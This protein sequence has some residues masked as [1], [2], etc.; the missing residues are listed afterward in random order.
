MVDVLG[1]QHA[2]YHELV[3]GPEVEAEDGRAEEEPRPGHEAVPVR[4]QEEI[5]P[6]APR[7]PDEREHLIGRLRLV[8]RPVIRQYAERSHIVQPIDHRAPAPDLIESEIRNQN[9]T[10]DE[11]DGLNDLGLDHRIQSARNGVGRRGHR[12]DG[13]DGERTELGKKQFQNDRTHVQSR[14]RIQQYVT[15]D[16]HEAEVVPRSFVV[17]PLQ[18]LRHGVDLGFQVERQEED[19]EEDQDDRGKPFVIEYLGVGLVGIPRQ[20][21]QRTGRNVGRE[22]RDTDDGP[23][24]VPPRQE[25][26]LGALR[27]GAVKAVSDNENGV[28]RH[29][30]VINAT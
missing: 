15:H 2:L 19:G 24:H 23:G 11:Q 3:V 29:H 30:C 12:Q 20:P 5:A 8:D 9:T 7:R 17:A 10:E 21:D 25:I 1:P 13:H 22:E 28:E 27:L 18:E 26:L 16:G 4:A 14:R 6:G